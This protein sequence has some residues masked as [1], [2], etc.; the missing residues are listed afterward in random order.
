MV[1]DTTPADSPSKAILDNTTYGRVGATGA[2]LNGA[3]T[4]SGTTVAVTLAGE[5]WTTAG[6]DFAMDITADAER[7]TAPAS[8]GAST[9]SFTGCTRGV[10]PAIAVAHANGAAVQVWQCAKV[11]MG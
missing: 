1:L 4:S 8:G 5:L 2:I 3:L 7:I 9:P 11:A 10:A 6:G